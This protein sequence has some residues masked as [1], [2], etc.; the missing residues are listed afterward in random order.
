[1]IKPHIK[2]IIDT[3]FTELLSYLLEDFGSEHNELLKYLPP[4]T[5]TQAEKIY[6]EE[7][8]T[9]IFL[10]R[11]ETEIVQPHLPHAMSL[12]RQHINVGRERTFSAWLVMLLYCVVEERVPVHQRTIPNKINCPKGI[13][14]YDIKRHWTKKIEPHL[15]ND[16]VQD[17]LIKDF[18]KFTFGRWKQE[19]K[20]GN[21]PHEFE[22]CDWFCEHKGPMPRFWQYVKHSA[23]HYLVNFNLELAMQ[24]EP[25]RIW[26]IVTSDE[27]STVWDGKK[28]LFDMNFL[29]LG[30]TAKQA[31]NY[32]NEQH[33]PPGQHLQVFLAEPFSIEIENIKNKIL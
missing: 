30:V 29:A 28:T 18:N 33:L 25:S 22:S 23:C 27:H 2:P 5:I 26:R 13:R 20:S 3:D 14:Y 7:P 16:K 1:M 8:N 9:K 21:V 6:I 32:S 15:A 24:V 11:C 19:F 4:E 17:A 31:F 12:L 10:Q